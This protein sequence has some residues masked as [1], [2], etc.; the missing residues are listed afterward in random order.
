MVYCAKSNLTILAGAHAFYELEGWTITTI[1]DQFLCMGSETFVRDMSAMMSLCQ[2]QAYRFPFGA[3]IHGQKYQTYGDQWITAL[4]PI[5]TP[6]RP[7]Q[8]FTTAPPLDA[9]NHPPWCC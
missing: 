9:F 8:P 3:A 2:Y 5:G 6:E 4:A 1:P 7:A